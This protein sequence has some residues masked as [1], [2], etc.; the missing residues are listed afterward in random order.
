MKKLKYIIVGIAGILGALS[1]YYLGFTIDTL[2]HH[3]LP[4]ATL[5][6]NLIGCFLLALL[7]TYIARL[8]ILSSEVITGIGTGFIGSFTTFSTFSVET[9]KLINHS[10]LG[11]AFL[12][13]LCSMLGG[14]IMSGLGYKLGDF[15]L[16]K[17]LEEGE[18][19]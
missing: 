4:L 1:R 9:V 16:Q 15:L 13:V 3:S 6:I 7:T 12:Y 5:T 19:S 17:H 2:W 8:N 14:L 10:E 18:L 11:I